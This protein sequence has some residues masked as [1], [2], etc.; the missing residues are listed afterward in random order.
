MPKYGYVTGVD[1]SGSSLLEARGLNNR[2]YQIDGEHLPFSD[3][4]FDCVYTSHVF[5]H[6]PLHQKSRVVNEIPRVLKPGG[7]LL[8]SIECDSESIVYKRAKKYSE[9]FSIC[10]VEHW[11]HYGLELPDANFRRFRKAGFLPVVELADIHKGYLRPVSSY[12]NLR[13]YQNKDTVLFWLGTLSNWIDK[14]YVLTRVIDFVFGM[15]VPATYLFTPPNHRDS[16]KVVY[17]KPEC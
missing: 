4:S 15:M 3:A 5:G 6:I 2:V 10:F 12:K 14:S 9:I 7:Y 17:Q 8:G 11:G 16:A 13:D 1:L